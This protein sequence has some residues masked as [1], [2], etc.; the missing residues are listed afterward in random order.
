M[1][2]RDDIREFLTS[3][4]ARLTPAE[5]GLPDFGG[6]RRVKGLRR[7]EVALLAGMSTEYYVRLERGNGTGVSEAVLDGISRA[8]QLDEAEHAHLYALVKAADPGAHPARRRGPS[9]PQQVRPA[10]QQLIDTMR[11]VP[12]YVQN[13]RLDAVAT[14][15]LGAALF[16]EM[17]VLPQRPVNAA[18][19]TFLD[20]RAPTF[21]RDWPGNARQ[22]VALLRAVAGRAPHDRVLS[23]LVGELATRS[24]AFRTLWASHD[25]RVHRTGTKQVHHPV[26]GDLDLTFEALDLTSEPGL[27]LLAFTAAPGSASRDGLQLLATWAATARLESEGAAVPAAGTADEA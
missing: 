25:V 23:D 3:R 9:R 19:F 20:P 8:L 18:R 17:F 4:R 2:R 26:V 5:A 12:V 24:E 16:S 11:D 10:V 22:I 27:Q 1:D 14:N 21:Y 13:G 7:E 6:R 15:R